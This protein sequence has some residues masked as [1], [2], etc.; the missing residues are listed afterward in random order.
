VGASKIDGIEKLARD[1]LRS[2]ARAPR[3]RRHPPFSQRP[4]F[5]KDDSPQVR[6]VLLERLLVVYWAPLVGYAHRLLGDAAAAE[7]VVQRAFVRLYERD[8]VLPAGDEVRPFLYR[9]VRNLVVNEWRR[10]RIREQW[11]DEQRLEEEPVAL[12]DDR[13]DRLELRTAIELAVE[14]LPARRREIFTLSRFHELTNDEIA[15]V[16]GISSQTVANQ[17]VSALRTLR[18]LLRPHRDMSQYPPL[19]IVRPLDRST[20]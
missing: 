16:L 6:T 15:D 13:L 14:S 18:E 11:L 19:K 7:D 12:P 9:I 10:E 5:S 17:L 2:Y 20:G 1:V 3:A 4:V 8:H